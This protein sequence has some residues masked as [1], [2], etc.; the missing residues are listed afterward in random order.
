MAIVF[1]K[2]FALS[3]FLKIYVSQNIWNFKGSKR[4]PIKES[5]T[6]AKASHQYNI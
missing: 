5:Q 2:I 4:Y 6:F 3:P 1:N